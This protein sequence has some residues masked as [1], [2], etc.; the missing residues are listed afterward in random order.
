MKILCQPAHKVEQD[1]HLLTAQ[2]LLKSYFNLSIRFSID[3]CCVDI[4]LKP[5]HLQVEEERGRE[6]TRLPPARGG[7]KEERSAAGVE[8]EKEEK[9]EKVEMVEMSEQ[10]AKPPAAPRRKKK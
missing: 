7:G 5:V 9:V 1:L 4:L 3:L 8:V 6:R 10:P 2:V